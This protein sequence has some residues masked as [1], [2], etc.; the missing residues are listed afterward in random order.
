MAHALRVAPRLTHSLRKDDP[1]SNSVSTIST[2]AKEPV[3]G[4]PDR[5]PLFGSSG[6][7]ELCTTHLCTHVCCTC[8]PARE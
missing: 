2:F 7:T 5:T 4:E 6:F 3:R 8:P 1:C